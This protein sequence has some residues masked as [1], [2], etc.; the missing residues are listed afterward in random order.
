MKGVKCFRGS[1]SD[2]FSRFYNIQVEESFTNVFRFTADNPFIDL[3]KLKS[4]YHSFLESDVDYA[5][6]KGMPL[7]MNFEVMK[8]NLLLDL[9]R[10]E[11]SSEE[12]E[13]VTLIIHRRNEI[14]K[15]DLVIADSADIRMTVDTPIDYAQA[16]LIKSWLA[17]R[18]DLGSILEL[19]NEKPW[20]FSL[21]D[22]IIQMN[23]SSSEKMQVATIKKIC[24]DKGYNKVADLL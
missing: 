20:I 9:S 22:G 6:S 4:F 19:K 15:A 13:H 21:N 1:E 10:F 16:S 2:V 14:K 17:D 8:G 24:I 3:F 7:G 11:L 12:K 23:T 5:Y 18:H